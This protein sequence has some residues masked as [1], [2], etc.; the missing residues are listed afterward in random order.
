[1]LRGSTS[2]V[3]LEQSTDATGA[4][5]QRVVT[6]RALLQDTSTT[7]TTTIKD[8]TVESIALEAEQLYPFVTEKPPSDSHT[9]TFEAAAISVSD[10][11]VKNE[12]ELPPDPLDP[13]WGKPS[14][15]TLIGAAQRQIAADFG[16]PARLLQGQNE[17][18]ALLS[19]AGG[20]GGAGMAALSMMAADSSVVQQ[21]QQQF[22]VLL[23][24]GLLAFVV[25][26]VI[27]NRTRRS[28][29]GN[30]YQ[31]EA[32]VEEKEIFE[33]D[34]DGDSEAYALFR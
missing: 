2:A 20:G 28:K 32:F 18:L 7:A 25:V 3:S 10:G 9:Q 30:S 31:R 1:M 34:G 8:V 11:H 24:G 21:L 22:P 14:D 5:Q 33:S 13:T 16:V 19:V 27:V 17:Q 4:I 15:R 23:V 26:G 12:V 6:D 29:S